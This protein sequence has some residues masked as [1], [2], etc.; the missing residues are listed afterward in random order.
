MGRPKGSRN[1]FTN[2][3]E[4][5]LFAYKGIGGDM[6]LVE[7]AQNP[8]NKALFYQL[9]AKM[10]PRDM[11]VEADVGEKFKEIL[12]KFVEARIKAEKELRDG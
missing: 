4:S 7:W 8:K 3:R 11:K 12:D 2:L 10:L 1:K 5:F 9:L 6:A